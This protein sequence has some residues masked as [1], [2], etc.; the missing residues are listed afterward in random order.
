MLLTNIIIV[1]IKIVLILVGVAYFTIAERKVMAAVQR[2]HGPDVVGF[3]GLL[4]PL[5]DGLK[6]VV[7][8]LLIPTKTEHIGFLLSPIVILTLSLLS[9]SI[10]PFG[11]DSSTGNSMI[12]SL[13]EL[14]YANI[15]TKNITTSI[16]SEI[17]TLVKNVSRPANLHY[18]VLFLLAVSS[19]NVY[20]I[21]LAG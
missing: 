10:I 7:K 11:F 3:I 15:N 21:I 17:F 19:F 18:G 16:F 14:E 8:E 2:R 9:W 12:S 4:Q 13:S 1:L 5:A 20:G 6:L